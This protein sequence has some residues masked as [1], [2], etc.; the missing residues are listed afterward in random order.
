MRSTM[1]VAGFLALG[2]AGMAQAAP[3]AGP[4]PDLTPA[5][6]AQAIHHKPGHRGGPPWMRG[7]AER[8]RDDDRRAYRQRDRDDWDDD[9]PSR[10]TTACRTE[11]REAF[12]PYR[13]VSIRRPVQVC[14][15]R[16][17]YGY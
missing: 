2:L 9:R 17:G 13:G 3:L 15:E 14:R 11:Y 7:R 6:P 1:L 8:D 5:T 10:R 16:Y 4:Q 12:D